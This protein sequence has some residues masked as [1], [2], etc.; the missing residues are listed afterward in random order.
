M[1]PTHKRSSEERDES[2]LPPPAKT[3]FDSGPQNP[4]EL[5]THKLYECL[6]KLMPQACLFTIIEPPTD[7]I[8][9]D[10]KNVSPNLISNIT[11]TNH[12]PGAEHLDKE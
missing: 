7:E 10:K 4:P 5:Q 11:S 6:H 8:E 2:D 1:K 12:E 9:A 3:K